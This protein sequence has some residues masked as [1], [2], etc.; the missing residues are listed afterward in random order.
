MKFN[1]H[2]KSIAMR[3]LF[4]VYLIIVLAVVAIAVILS[5]LFSSLIFSTVQSQATDYAQGFENL[6]LVDKSSFYDT[7]IILS[8]EFEYKNKIEVQVINDAGRVIVSTTG[9]QSPDDVTAEYNRACGNVSGKTL[10]RGKNSNGEHI[11]A[12]THA[13][14]GS[15]GEIIGAYRWVTSLKMAYK[16]INISITLITFI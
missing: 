1:F 16:N 11:M 7:A 5:M 14:H 12:G 3:W 2:F 6:S 13:I 4:K 10:Y 15:K 8:D 9:F